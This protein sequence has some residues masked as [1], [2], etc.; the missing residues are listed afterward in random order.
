MMGLQKLTPDQRSMPRSVIKQAFEEI[1]ESCHRIRSILTEATTA[2]MNDLNIPLEDYATID[3]SMSHA[4][5]R[6]RDEVSHPFRTRQMQLLKRVKNPDGKRMWVNQPSTL[7]TYH[8]F[9]GMEV[10]A[11]K[12][13]D[14]TSQVYFISTSWTSMEMDNL[15]LSY[16]WP[17]TNT[18]T[19]PGEKD[20]SIETLSAQHD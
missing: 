1:P 8:K 14:Q 10:I 5:Q 9:H 7:Q 16:G 15:A 20:G 17:K 3:V 19:C 2:I 4:F 18:D 6:I 13:D 11:I 12:L